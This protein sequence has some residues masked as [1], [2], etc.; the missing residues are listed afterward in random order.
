MCLDE[1]HKHVLD[2]QI[3]DILGSDK[4]GNF[5]DFINFSQNDQKWS[6]EAR[7]GPTADQNRSTLPI[8]W[9]R[10]HG[11]VNLSVINDSP[12]LWHDI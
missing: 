5:F 6:Y 10:D 9:P 1:G 2:G 7:K 11:R 8:S 12:D 4:F 3:L